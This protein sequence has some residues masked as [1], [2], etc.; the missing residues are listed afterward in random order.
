[1]KFVDWFAGIGGFRLGLEKQGFEHVASCE[2][3]PFPRRVYAEHFGAAPTWKDVTGVR[4]QDI[5]QA[6][7]WAGGFPCQD[8]SVAG[9]S[10][11][12]L[13]GA[14]SGLVF[15]L[16]GLASGA[17]ERRG[18]AGYRV[19]R[20]AVGGGYLMPASD[21]DAFVG[22]MD[23]MLCSMERDLQLSATEIEGIRSEMVQDGGSHSGDC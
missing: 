3:A 17:G 23:K 12:L 14:R 8:V 2:L 21:G 18:R 1:M 9:E 16:L 6:D 10:R 15:R 20:E 22:A 4:T 11:G 5:P 7:L 13:G 19:D